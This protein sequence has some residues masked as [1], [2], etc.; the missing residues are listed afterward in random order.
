[1]ANIPIWQGVS[2]FVPGTGQTPFG[3]YDSDPIFQLDVDKFARHAGY[4]LGF[5]VMDVELQD[6]H[7]YAAFEAAIMEYSN[8]LY[9]FKIMD[10]YLSYE[11][12]QIPSGS[13][14][15][16]KLIVPSLGNLIR[17]SKTYGS[18]TGTGGLVNYYS[19]SI[20][21]SEGQ[22]DYDLNAWSAVSG[23]LAPNDSIEIKK[24]FHNAPPASVRWIDPYYG[25][26]TAQAYAL[27]Q[28]TW[29]NMGVTTNYMMMPVSYDVA[30]FQAIEFN[31]EIRRSTYSFEIINNKLRIFPVPYFNTKLWF[32]YVKVSERDKTTVGLD[33]TDP[34]TITI[35]DPSNVP[36]QN[37]I[38][39]QINAPG[40]QWILKYGVALAKSMLAAIRGKY[41]S[42]P[43][44]GGDLALNYT[45]LETQA[46]AEQDSLLE[47]L[48]DFLQK[49]SRSAQMEKQQL[50]SDQLNG[51][52]KNIPMLVYVG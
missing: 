9:R 8:E 41:Q 4:R 37:I 48:R 45:S 17:I 10:N 12:S 33:I 7:F 52:L 39:G 15:N 32:Q 26:Q 2:H 22:Q 14:F 43:T 44:A 34:S 1:M 16:N 46:A 35:T 18:E 28:A 47:S 19:G 6:I 51:T 11:G 40:K 50:E 21:I 23:S 25:S 38:Y 42:I 30:R 49:T 5:P 20:A 3:Y 24:I 13:V 27:D 29:N 36:F 31:D